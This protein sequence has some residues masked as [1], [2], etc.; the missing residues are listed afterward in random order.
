VVVWSRYRPGMAQRVG[1]G[2]ALFFHDRGTRKGWVVNST[3]WP[4]FTPR[5]EPVPIV[6]EAGCAP[7]LVWT[8]GKSRPHRDSIPDRPVRSQSLYRLSYPAHHIQAI[9][10][11]M[12]QYS[13]HLLPCSTYHTLSSQL[14]LLVSEIYINNL[15]QFQLLLA[16][17]GS[18]KGAGLV[19]AI[20]LRLKQRFSE[21]WPSIQHLAWQETWL[22]AVTSGNVSHRKTAIMVLWLVVTF[23][24]LWNFR[25]LGNGWSKM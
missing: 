12:L 1:R 4:H 5:K 17:D 18:G 10:I 24:Q 2:I 19:A 25:L 11:V 20:A 13:L 9:F 3:P 16:E 22:C 23:R 21:T 7:G 6:Q 8:G 14:Q 15:F